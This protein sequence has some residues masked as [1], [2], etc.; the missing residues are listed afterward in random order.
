MDVYGKEY[1]VMSCSCVNVE[2]ILNEQYKNGY[3]LHTATF[4]PDF[5]HEYNLIFR[6][7]HKKSDETA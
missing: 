4:N 2:Y 3:E 6:K 5:V 1:K 7:I